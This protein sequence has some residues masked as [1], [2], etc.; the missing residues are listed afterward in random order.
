M[1]YQMGKRILYSKGQR[2]CERED[3]T[4]PGRESNPHHD[5]RSVVS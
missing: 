1:V 4:V 2:E 3:K 5:V